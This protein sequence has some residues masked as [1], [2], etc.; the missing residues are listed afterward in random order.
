VAVTGP[1]P[2]APVRVLLPPSEAKT[3]GGRGRPLGER[4]SHPVLATHR[5]Q[6]LDSLEA[7]LRR[8]RAS[9]AADL[10]LPASVVDDVLRANAVV[11]SSPTMRALHRYAGVVY[12]GLAYSD[13]DA[14]ARRV[15]DREVLVFSGLFGVVRGD[16]AVPDYR[17][18]AKA[19]L[20]GI[21]IVGTSWRPVLDAAMPS[22]MGDEDLI[23][24]R[25][26]D[27][28]AMWRPPR[29]TITVR[30]LSRLPSGAWGVI[31]YNSKFAKGRL[32]AALVR[33][34]AAGSPVLQ[35]DH[36][37]AAWHDTTGLRVDIPS[38]NRVEI[39]T[40]PS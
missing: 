1:V 17:V 24:L 36:V 23:D 4:D 39:Y 7:L 9:V 31:S 27:Y 19:N 15:A 3:T 2:S 26:S 14:R 16:E 12:D 10:L 18:P 40:E 6:L 28:A 22:L 37:A 5:S 30:A 20:P 32:A 11:R 33:L 34:R 25:S 29:S 35:A 38:D 21:G 13:L 8:D